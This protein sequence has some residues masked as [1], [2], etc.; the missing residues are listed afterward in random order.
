MWTFFNAAYRLGASCFFGLRGAT[1]LVVLVQFATDIVTHPLLGTD[2]NPD[3]ISSADDIATFVSDLVAAIVLSPY[4]ILI[5]RRIILQDMSGSYLTAATSSR[6]V[7]FVAAALI[8]VAGSIP[9][10]FADVIVTRTDALG[11]GQS[12]HWS[13]IIPM[14]LTIIW[15]IIFL[16]LFLAFPAIATDGSSAPLSDSFRDTKGSSWWLVFLFILVAIP[17]VVLEGGFAYYF[18]N[19]SEYSG[20]WWFGEFRLIVLGTFLSAVFVAL[21]S[22]LYARRGQWSYGT[23]G[24]WSSTG[25]RFRISLRNVF[26]VIAM[27]VVIPAT[28]YFTKYPFSPVPFRGNS[29]ISLLCAAGVGWYVWVKLRSAPAD[30]FSSTLLGAILLGS[31]GFD[32]GFFG[33]Q[34]FVPGSNEGPVLGMFITGPIGFIFGAIFGL[35]CSFGRGRKTR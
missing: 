2:S 34:I 5:H 35:V 26:R 18:G 1:V 6:V 8:I 27:L 31:A 32:V 4:A 33:P 10:R 29:I 17:I 20:L 13:V 25:H 12:S 28:Y 19:G 15:V 7:R 3:E 14:I 9:A 22:Y 11:L 30:T 23:G 24:E 16:R 21:A